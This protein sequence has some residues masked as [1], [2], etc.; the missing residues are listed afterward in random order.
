MSR[1]G[2]GL[3]ALVVAGIAWGSSGTLGTLLARSSGLPLLAIGGY[4]I[5]VGGLLVGAFILAT[6]QLQLPRRRAGWLRVLAIAA[7]SAL[8]QVSFFTAIGLIG[9]A[10]ATLVAIGSAPIMVLV[11]DAAT[12]RHR[13]GLRLLATLAMAVAGLVLLVGTPPS[14]VGADALLRGGVLALAAGSGFAGISLIGARPASDFQNLTGT[15][16]AFG[17]GGLGVLLIAASRGTVTFAPTPTAIGLVVALGLIPTAIAYLAYLQGLRTQSSTT[18]ALVS[19]L[20]PLTAALLA[21]LVLGERL[22]IP[23]LAGAALL[24]GAVALTATGSR[25]RTP[26]AAGAL[27]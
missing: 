12:G 2:A 6:R 3:G 24:L 5:A 16:L 17:I 9:V 26:P 10:L 1:G 7:C 14:G 8:Y 15:A 23:T 25:T 22:T 13:L 27:G 19:L 18:G 4:R 20:E 21:A 11:V